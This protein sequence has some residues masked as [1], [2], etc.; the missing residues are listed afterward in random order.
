LFNSFRSGFSDVSLPSDRKKKEGGALRTVDSALVEDCISLVQR[1]DDEGAYLIRVGTLRTIVTIRLRRTWGSRTAYRQSHAIK[2]PRQPCP[3]WSCAPEAESP[4]EA[5]HKAISS[6]TIHYRKAVG[7]GYLP[8][9][10]WLV[11][12]ERDALKIIR[13][14]ATM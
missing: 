2:T 12:A 14:A 7:E 8:R 10:E 9:E 13:D 4:G 11:P 6:L 5:L 1:R 3:D